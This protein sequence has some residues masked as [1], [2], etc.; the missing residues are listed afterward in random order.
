MILAIILPLI[1]LTT[2]VMAFTLSRI[3]TAASADIQQ[4][5]LEELEL[6]A[7]R[8]DLLFASLAQVASSTAT[9]LEVDE[10]LREEDIYEL[11]ESNV[12]HNALIHGA[13]VTFS[14]G[15]FATGRPLFAPYVHKDCEQ[16]QRLDK[17]IS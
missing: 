13:A 9:F 12:E 17:G 5:T 15:A 10:N 7:A 1:V 3:Y 8:L 11:L 14:P 16:V 4:R 2:G 6:H